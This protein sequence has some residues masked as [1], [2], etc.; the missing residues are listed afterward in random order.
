MK[1]YNK[2]GDE[3]YILY[4]YKEG[5]ET[6]DSLLIWDGE[7]RRG[8]LSYVIGHEFITVSGMLDE[9]IKREIVEKEYNIMEYSSE[10]LSKLL[11][12]VSSLKIAK[13]KIIMEVKDGEVTFWSGWIP[14]REVS[15][16][17]L[18]HND[19]TRIL[20]LDKRN[21]DI[22][23]GESLDESE[24]YIDGADLQGINIITGEKGSGKSHLAKTLLTNII[25][26][27]GKAIVIDLNNEYSGL[28]VYENGNKSDLFD[29][30]IVLRP[31][32]DEFCFKTSE[33]GLKVMQV[34]LGS[35]LNLPDRSTQVFTTV[36]KWLESRGM[37][38]TLK[39]ITDTVNRLNIHESIK[40]AIISRLSLLESMGLI[41]DI[42]ET[43]D[44]YN[45]I[46]GRLREGGALIINLRG[47]DYQ[48]MLVAIQIL[49]SKIAEI[50]ER[51]SEGIF[52]F[53]EEAQLYMRRTEWLNL[54]TRVRHL[55]LYQFYIT[56]TPKSIPPEA[57]EQADN[58]FLYRLSD[59]DDVRYVTSIARMDA[60]SL[61]EL[62]NSIPYRRFILFG[63]ASKYY[64]ITV[65]NIKIPYITA[66]MT[67]R[68]W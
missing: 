57:I 3:L 12:G 49:I 30:I 67:K 66:G 51:S 21:V 32:T 23:I 1:L 36:W 68:I 6:G 47:L 48:T 34:I 41:R 45:L 27:G 5:L 55:G 42:E 43:T 60:R 25:K 22:L 2:V 35:I 13:A 54:I 59:E 63:K 44:L 26:A 37:E 62:A 40:D 28:R 33:V 11:S 64:P 56:N 20:M 8:L 24:V 18:S 53:I 39:N 16:K 61:R 19:L 17:R 50:L 31:G 65:N 38:P 52:I 4:H 29:K 14:T 9:L 7:A 58:L 10:E 15:I 46:F